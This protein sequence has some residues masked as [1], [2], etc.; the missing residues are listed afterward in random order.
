MADSQDSSVA[1]QSAAIRYQNLLDDANRRVD[2]LRA[3]DGMFA[4]IRLAF[5]GAAI[6]VLGLAFFANLGAPGW[7][8][9]F[10]LLGGFLVA[11]IFNEP[12]RD[13]MAAQQRAS[14]VT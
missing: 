6:V 8:V 1:A 3:R 13:A 14:K 10:V 5:F 4:M 11:A 2:Q 7:I 9:G 12:V